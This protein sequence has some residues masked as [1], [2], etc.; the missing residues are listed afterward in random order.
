MS[1]S[2]A[3]STIVKSAQTLAV[4]KLSAWIAGKEPK[5][6]G[7]PDSY[8]DFLLLRQRLI[9]EVDAVLHLL[10]ALNPIECS[11]V[12]VAELVAIAQHRGI[13]LRHHVD[14][15]NRAIAVRNSLLRNLATAE[16]AGIDSVL[17]DLASASQE[18]VHSIADNHCQGAG[19]PPRLRLV[20]Q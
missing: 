6:A 1:S 4:G 11:G 16:L 5:V 13:W 12:S 10:R 19:Q 2:S 17:T 7:W 14:A 9:T 15:W 20:A 3:F 8:I 18:L